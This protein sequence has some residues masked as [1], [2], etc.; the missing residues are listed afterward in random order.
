MLIHFVPSILTVPAATV[1]FLGFS[2][3]DLGL[4]LAANDQLLL[5][6][7]FTNRDWVVAAPFKHVL[8]GDKVAGFFIER[9]HVPDKFSTQTRWLYTVKDKTVEI[10][11]IV[12]YTLLDREYEAISDS[13]LLWFGTEN[14]EKGI[15][16]AGRRPDVYVKKPPL[17]FKP[18]VNAGFGKDTKEWLTEVVLDDGFRKDLYQYLTGTKNPTETGASGYPLL[19]WEQEFV[20]H[21][22]ERERLVDSI[23]GDIYRHLPFGECGFVFPQSDGQDP[24]AQYETGDYW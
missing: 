15:S 17:S 13:P 9:E 10:K 20:T 11:H 1:E 7:P 5:N 4:D 12:N 16:F 21:T 6:R 18:F 23:Y 2:C 22:F 3:A 8:N 19:V 24:F 14:R